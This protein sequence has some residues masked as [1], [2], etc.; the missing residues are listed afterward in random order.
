MTV[1]LRYLIIIN[2]VSLLPK[3][4]STVFFPHFEQNFGTLNAQLA[5]KM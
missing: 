1:P 4:Q 5:G 3:E 2:I